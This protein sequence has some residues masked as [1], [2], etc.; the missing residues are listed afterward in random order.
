MLCR[1]RTDLGVSLLANGAVD[2]GTVL[3]PIHHLKS[4]N[5]E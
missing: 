3:R 1:R 4:D 2:D 5:E